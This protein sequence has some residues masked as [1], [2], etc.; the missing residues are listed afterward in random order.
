MEEAVIDD[1][2]S[3]ESSLNDE[4]LTLI[5]SD[6]QLASTV[7]THRGVRGQKLQETKKQPKHMAGHTDAVLIKSDAQ[8]NSQP[9]AAATA[10]VSAMSSCSSCRVR[11]WPDGGSNS[12]TERGNL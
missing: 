5:D 4:Y 1:I 9:A 2:I 7:T 11:L 3:L 8:I 12:I 10:S 6:L